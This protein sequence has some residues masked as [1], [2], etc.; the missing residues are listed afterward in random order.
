MENDFRITTNY[1]NDDNNRNVLNTKDIPEYMKVSTHFR[2]ERGDLKNYDKYDSLEFSD[3]SFDFMAPDEDEA[4]VSGLVKP[5]RVKK[6]ISDSDNTERDVTVKKNVTDVHDNNDI[7]AGDIA[8][9]NASS[10]ATLPDFMYNPILLLVM[11]IFF[12]GLIALEIVGI[13]FL[14]R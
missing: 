5:V 12:I 13:V 8:L 6:E 3:N 11:L 14:L 9:S 4:V 10:A 2:E 1:K 7:F